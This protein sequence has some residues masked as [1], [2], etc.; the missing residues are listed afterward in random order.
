MPDWTPA[1]RERMAG[2]QI[3]PE[4]EASV[5]EE[6]S[7][8]L[9]D[10]Y[11]ELV[12]GG[13]SAEVARNAV[14]DE[15]AGPALVAALAESLPR[16]APSALPPPDE[17]GGQGWL[18]RF[19]EGLPLRRAAPRPRAG[20]RPRGDPVARARHRSEHG[21]LPAPRRRPHAAPPDR[22]A[23][24]PVQPSHPSEL[25]PLRQLHGPLAAADLGALGADSRRTE[26]VLEARRLERRPR[27]PRL[28]RRGALRRGSL[29]QRHVLRHGRQ[30]ARCAAGFSVPPTTR[31]TARRRPSCSPSRSGGGSSAAATSLPARRCAIEGRRFEIA[32]VTPARF[33]G[34]EVGRAFDVVIP[35]CAGRP[36]R[37]IAPHS[38]ALRLVALRDRPARARLDAPPSPGARGGVV[39]GGFRSDAAARLR[40][41]D[42]EDLSRAA[43]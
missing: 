23:R 37:R 6:I 18:V 33:F 41:A 25:Q 24:G 11:T 17:G 30:S 26:G 13:A 40:R 2:L 36:H 15:L 22:E 12:A 5:V 9:D 19:R 10:R 20:V 29:G 38:A 14:L 27:Q 1:I 31:P 43:S 39:T 16:P 8:H 34:V 35:L 4:R 7:Q 32:G 3:E 21:H 42:R 28:G